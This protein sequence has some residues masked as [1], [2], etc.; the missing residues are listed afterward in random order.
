[1]SI[2]L[3]RESCVAQVSA[4]D[5]YHRHSL[6]DW[7]SQDEVRGSAIAV[8]GAGAVG[9]EVIKNLT[10]LGVGRIDIYDFDK[11]EQ[12]NLT[13][14]VLFREGDIGSSKAQTSAHRASELDSSVVINAT[15]GDF[16]R[17]LPLSRLHEYTSVV[18]CVDNFESRIRINL[19]CKL[20]GV[21]LINIGIDS[22]FASV[23]VFPFS[24]GTQIA[25]YECTLPPSVYRRISQRYS[26][27]G[28]RKLGYIERKVPTTIITSSFAGAVAV[29]FALR[30]G[31]SK[32]N[33]ETIRY[34]IDSISGA[35]ATAR[36]AKNPDC[37]ACGNV[38]E[39]VEL[40]SCSGDLIS[41]LPEWLV[42]DCNEFTLRLSDRLIVSRSCELCHES[43]PIG[44][45]AHGLAR[46]ADFDS[47]LEACPNCTQESAKIE[48]RDELS[49]RELLSYRGQYLPVKFVRCDLTNATVVFDIEG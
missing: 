23:E 31:E 44:Q 20:A 11:I 38:R 43:L 12:H 48:M 18:C 42:S 33:R 47:S 1:L 13:R 2:E 28:L 32:E 9:N 30:L 46:A 35:S 8:I 17:T 22:R 24:H 39:H 16:W 15:D 5:R 26:C 27:G 34:F 29:S 14:S 7:F 40:I 21:D 25:C 3:T 6:I 4:L 19:M 41:K 45:E 49:I 10:L 37:V 36:V